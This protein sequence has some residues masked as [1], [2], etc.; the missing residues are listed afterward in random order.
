MNPPSTFEQAVDAIVAGDLRT[1]ERA[2]LDV[3][4]L[5]RARS[6]REHQATLLHYVAAN[7]VEDERQKTPPN[8]VRIAEFLLDSGADV[9]ATAAMYGGKATTIGLAATSIHPEKAGV[10]EALMQLLLDRGATLDPTLISACLANGRSRA[11]EWLA[12][13]G[14]DIDLEAAAGLGRL[15]RVQ[16]LFDDNENPRPPTT[17]LQLE[18]G[19]LWASEYG[20]NDVI[21]FLLQRGVPVNAAADTGQTALHWAVIGGQV[22]TITLLLSHGAN[23]EARNRYGGTALGQAMWSHAHSNG[24]VNYRA[25]IDAL[26]KAGALPET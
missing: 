17:Q 10:Q 9:N 4:E 15:D 21:E 1:L 19:F 13:H 12:E 5:I 14:A 25:A 7:G 16:S 20:H 8:I 11:A 2:L 3:P 24:G 18:R 22:E 6:T 23:L 26:L